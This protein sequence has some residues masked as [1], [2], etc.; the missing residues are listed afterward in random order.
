VL[1]VVPDTD[2]CVVSAAHFNQCVR[3]AAGNCTPVPEHCTTIVSTIPIDACDIARRGGITLEQRTLEP[4]KSFRV[5]APYAASSTE[6][7]TKVILARR[8]ASTRTPEE[9]AGGGARVGMDE[10]QT[11]RITQ[12]VLQPRADFPLCF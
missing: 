6:A 8:V 4:S 10:N 11:T 7:D 5:I 12:A 2:A 9:P 3:V 1:R